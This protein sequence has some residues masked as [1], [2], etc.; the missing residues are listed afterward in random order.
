MP[1]VDSEKMHLSISQAVEHI[2][3]TP[4]HMTFATIGTPTMG[5]EITVSIGSGGAF[6]VIDRYFGDT[7]TERHPYLNGIS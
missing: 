1:I 4:T 2:A 7:V 5:F 6:K 3:D